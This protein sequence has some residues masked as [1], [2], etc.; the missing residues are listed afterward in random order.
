MSIFLVGMMG[1]GKSTI[2]NLVSKK[3]RLNFFDTDN[4]I[5]NNQIL[6][7]LD[8]HIDFKLCSGKLEDDI[9]I[10][11]NAKNLATSGVSAFPIACALMS[12]KLEKLI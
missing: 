1:S 12:Q 4:E 9:N 8:K 6:K 10:L 11:L 3:L 5:E 2:G 7:E